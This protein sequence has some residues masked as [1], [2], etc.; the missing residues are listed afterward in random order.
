MTREQTSIPNIDIVFIL[1]IL[2]NFIPFGLLCFLAFV[3][4]SFSVYPIMSAE[5]D[6]VAM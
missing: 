1:D 4:F 2:D 3:V 6:H 5:S